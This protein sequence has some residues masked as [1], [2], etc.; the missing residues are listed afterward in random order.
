M[1]LPR[2]LVVGLGDVALRALPDLLRGFEVW[3]LTR[4]VDDALW[5]RVDAACA[6]AQV[7]V[8]PRVLAFD[9]DAPRWSDA[10]CAVLRAAYEGCAAV[11]WTAPPL[12][13]RDG[14][15]GRAAVGRLARVW[16]LWGSCGVCSVRRWVYV[17]TTGVYGD[18]AGAWV[19]ELAPLRAESVRAQARV[20][21]EALWV[22]MARSA[23]ALVGGAL[24]QSWVLRAPGIYALDRLPVAQVLANAPVLEADEDGVGN[25][26]HA[27][28]LAAALVWAVQGVA[29]ERWLACASQGV[30]VVNVC[31]D[32]PIPMAD[33]MEV[34]ASVLGLGARVRLGREA[35]Q[36]QVGAVRW[37]FMRESRRVSNAR[38]KSM[39]FVLRYPSAL[40]FVR[41]H[42]EQIRALTWGGVGQGGV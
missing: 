32:V 39:G 9:L 18:C 7:S 23:Q 30:C 4:S 12:S 25:H 41:E 35:L 34:L 14:G 13:I 33:W 19:D 6:L 17:S 1:G 40:A 16:A 3:V 31:D 36:A 20:A 5:A 21:D 29:D 37:S 24:V 22:L 26:V 10:Q 15:E 8:R 27:D 38:L 42:A 28:D 11:V 2:V